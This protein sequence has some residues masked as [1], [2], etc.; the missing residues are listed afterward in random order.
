[1]KKSFFLLLSCLLYAAN[2]F[3]QGSDFAIDYNG[4]LTQYRGAGGDVVIPDGVIVIGRYAFS[5]CYSLNSVVIPNSV[6]VI[7]DFAFTDC[8]NLTSVTIPN[9]VT[10]IGR[11]AFENSGLTSISLPSSVSRLGESVFWG[12]IRLS[13]IDVEDN[14]TAYA[15]EEGVLYNKDKTSLIMYPSGKNE[16]TYEI[17]NS[18]ISIG[19]GALGNNNSLTSVI[20][21]SSVTSIAE[22]AFG[23]IFNL[24]S[25]QV[26]PANTAYASEE[27]VLYNKDKTFLHTYPKWKTETEFTLPNSVL[28]IGSSVFYNC[29]ALR[30]IN[31]PASV[32]TIDRLA[33]DACGNL[34][35]IHVDAANTVYASEAGVLYNKDKTTLVTYPLLKEGS[36]FTIPGSVTTIGDIAFWGCVYPTS[37]IIPES[38][39]TIEPGAFENC[40]N[41]ASITIPQSVSSIGRAAFFAC[42]S[43]DSIQVDAANTAYASEA[44]VLY[45]KNK[46]SLIAYPAGKDDSTFTVPNSVTIIDGYAFVECQGINSVSLS[47]SVKS[48]SFNAF[49]SCRNLASVTIPQSVESIGFNAFGDCDSLK[50]VDVNWET[51]LPLDAGEIVFARVD[52]SQATLKVPFGTAAAYRAAPVWADF[53]TITEK[54]KPIILP[55]S[56]SLNNDSITL[57]TGET[58]LLVESILPAE[59]DN[60]A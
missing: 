25:I 31:I 39:T 19:E 16:T 21:P 12:C 5:S 41:L 29:S 11:A 45:N 37:I 27:G 32:T 7:N 47:E 3:G 48:I 15:S 14:N 52:L 56:I 35:A 18:V 10:T 13:S 51:P 23:T 50:H 9:S 2:T 8:R 55:D 58:A 40:R 36:A 24:A 46:T 22:G 38:V 1:M 54:E 30:T 28:A 49:T 43:L 33:F 17:P 59:A 26:D 34:A 20:I 60:Q 53:G 4:V 6:A 57:K 42:I 44:G